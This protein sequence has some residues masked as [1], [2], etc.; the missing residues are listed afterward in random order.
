MHLKEI[1]NKSMK[2]LYLITLFTLIISGISVGQTNTYDGSYKV[3]YETDA[4]GNALTGELSNLVEYVNNGNPIRVGW[5]LEFMNPET[6][7]KDSFSHWAD[8]GF[9]T[10]LNGHIFAQ[11]QSI[12]QQGPSIQEPPS[13][14]LTSGEPNGWVAIIGTT[15]TM[16][17]K[18]KPNEAMRA[19][20]KA[21]GMT[22]EEITKL[23]KDQETMQVPTKWAVSINN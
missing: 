12:Y 22:D 9:I 14:F 11:I 4:K 15:G 13:V 1:N 8:A 3:A 16:R 21:D 2:H 6:G 19:M 5:T 7:E 17:Q 23:E 18:Y 20:L 10:I